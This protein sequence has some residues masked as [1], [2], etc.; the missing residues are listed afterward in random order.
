[1]VNSIRYLSWLRRLGVYRWI[2]ALTSGLANQLHPM[3]G[4]FSA[5]AI[6]GG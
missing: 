2:R 3:K 4:S 5:D 1:M 6:S